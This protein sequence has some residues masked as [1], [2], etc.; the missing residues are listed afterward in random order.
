MQN[1][2]TTL[3]DL[4]TQSDLTQQQLADLLGIT[5]STVSYYEKGD[6]TPS[7]E[8]LIQLASIFHVSTDYLLGIEKTSYLD[9]QGLTEDDVRI[10]R[11]LK[12][13]L[14]IKNEKKP[15]NPVK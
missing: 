15:T 4:R 1:F 9:T 3:K 7:P 5:K 11:Y 2:G 8:I 6:R 10:L 12:E 14:H 13:Y